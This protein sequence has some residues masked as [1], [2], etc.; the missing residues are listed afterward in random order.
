LLAE[1]FLTTVSKPKK[2]ALVEEADV[3]SENREL[4]LSDLGDEAE[5]M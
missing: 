4:Y 3:E 2:I 1:L 5:N